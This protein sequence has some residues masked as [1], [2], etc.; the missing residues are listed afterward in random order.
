[1]S[2]EGE[3]ASERGYGGLPLCQTCQL[4]L[5]PPAIM[6]PRAGIELERRCSLAGV[7][8]SL[9]MACMRWKGVCFE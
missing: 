4:P 3:R 5:A 8:R 2:L 6:L 9:A 7:T 1:M